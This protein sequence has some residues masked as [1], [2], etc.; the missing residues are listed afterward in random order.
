M[1][2]GETLPEPNVVTFKR[3]QST[4]LKAAP[5]PSTDYKHLKV[6]DPLLGRWI[7]TKPAEG[8][9]EADLQLDVQW[10]LN[11]NVQLL[12]ASRAADDDAESV[13]IQFRNWDESKQQ[14][15]GTGFSLKG[16]LSEFLIT[17]DGDK[18]VENATLTRPNGTKQVAVRTCIFDGDTLT[19]TGTNRV[20]DGVE[21][22]D[23]T[24]E[25]K[26]TKK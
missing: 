12:T 6:L 10:I 1:T 3:V 24:V 16:Q 21:Q 14:I 19:V 25:M 4:P 9:G 26:R 15:L 7:T 13:F 5:G 22:D 18:L 2:D 20:Q 17:A 11:K 23:W 8:I